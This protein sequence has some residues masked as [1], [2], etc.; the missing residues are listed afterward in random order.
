MKKNILC[1]FCLGTC[2]YSYNLNKYKIL[3]CSKCGT[4]QT[5]PMPTEKELKIFYDGFLFN[6]NPESYP[7]IQQSMTLLME[8]L[9][10]KKTGGNRM[11]D[12]GGGGG[13]YSLSFEKL[14][15]GETCYAD[16]DN[17]ACEYARSLGLKNVVNGNIENTHLIKGKYDLIFVRHVIEHLINPDKFMS[18]LLPY[19]KPNGQLV[20]ICPNG[21]STENLFFLTYT[22]KRIYSLLKSNNYNLTTLFKGLKKHI[23]HGIDPPRHLWAITKAGLKEYWIRQKHPC[24]IKTFF[25]DDK[26]V[27]P[28]FRKTLST[29]FY[30]LLKV[31][32]K[33]ESGSHLMCIIKAKNTLQKNN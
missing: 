6:T 30:R 22:I 1:P 28:L 16:L 2:T 33:R 9:N 27:S 13:Y 24:E 29:P 7:A 12:V 19:L 23:H 17:K 21:Y 20:I 14:H 31:G 10:I 3:T 25:I 4:G 11:L 32:L 26:M 15:Y 5:T 18:A 8:F